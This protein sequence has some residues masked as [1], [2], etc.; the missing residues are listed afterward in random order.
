MFDKLISKNYD[1]AMFHHAK[2]ILEV[3]MKGAVDD[4]EAV[5]LESGVSI[6]NLIRGG[7]GESKI[8]KTIRDKLH[9]KSWSKKNFTIRKIIDGIEKESISHEV[10]HVKAFGED[11]KRYTLAL[12]IEWNN[13][14]TFFDRDLENFQR[15]HSEGVISVGAIITRGTKFQEK[16]KSTLEEYAR[17]KGI[18]SI[19]TLREFYAPTVRQEKNI[20]RSVATHG[21]DFAK[22][23]AASFVADK[24][25]ESTT[26]WNKLVGRVKRGVGNPCPLLLIGLSDEIIS[27]CGGV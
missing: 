8:T 13:K 22:G 6:E 12:E 7:G 9:N 18:S 21:N 11:P 3:D 5:L 25:G 16:I 10:D 1:I 17:N 2:A 4:L 14:D 15:L 26:H 24:F 27:K 19:E 20:K 23:W